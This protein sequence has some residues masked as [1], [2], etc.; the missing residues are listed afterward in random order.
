MAKNTIKFV[1]KNKNA[2]DAV[3]Q[4]S[5]I[6]EISVTKDNYMELVGLRKEI[7]SGKTLVEKNGKVIGFVPRNA[8]EK[9]EENQ[10]EI[11]ANVEETSIKSFY[12]SLTT[13]LADLNNMPL[14]GNI[15]K[16]IKKLEK[17]IEI[18]ERDFSP[19]L[20]KDNS[21]NELSSLKEKSSKLNSEMNDHILKK[22]LEL[23]EK[24]RLEK[25]A[26]DLQIAKQEKEV[27]SNNAV[28]KLKNLLLT[29]AD[30]NIKKEN[31][32]ELNAIYKEMLSKE[33]EYVEPIQNNNTKSLFKDMVFK[34]GE[35]NIKEAAVSKVVVSGMKKGLEKVKNAKIDSSS[36]N[37]NLYLNIANSYAKYNKK[38]AEYY[39]NLV[40]S[41]DPNNEKAKKGLENLSKPQIKQEE[42][43]VVQKEEPKI[44]EEPK[45]EVKPQEVE[46]TKPVKEQL[47]L[48]DSQKLDQVLLLMS[49]MMKETKSI[50]KKMN[51]LE[52]KIDSLEKENAQFKRELE[53]KNLENKK[54]LIEN[55]ELRKELNINK[56]MSNSSVSK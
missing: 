8:L 1:V 43:K 5:K 26:I 49:E 15:S 11:I 56:D 47:P 33:K 34:A 52:N 19:I 3:S 10:E 28:N 20:K 39:Y 9:F 53:L 37:Q 35:F 54:L 23:L 36:F 27:S 14:T 42:K 31:N 38:D 44:K 18:F 22:E 16:E 6:K 13:K 45:V 2:I 24:K 48:T 29:K 30:R 21:N 46:L 40:L 41:K 32:D 55:E 4:V 17:K 7:K 50:K 12:D 25:E 51:K